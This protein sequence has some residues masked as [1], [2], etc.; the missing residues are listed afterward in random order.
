[1]KRMSKEKVIETIRSID[2]KGLFS[3]IAQTYKNFDNKEV[4]KKSRV[5]GEPTPARLQN[6]TILRCSTVSLG[7]DYTQAVNNR[8]LKEGKEADFQAKQSYTQKASENGL[9]LKHVEREQYYL[10]VYPNL[11]HSFHTVTKR[12]DANGVEISSEEWKKINAEYIK[13]KSPK[14]NQGLD[15][16]VL[17]NNYKIENVKYLKRGEIFIDKVTLEMEEKLAA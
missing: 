9:L 13:Q 10:R 6:I 17:V 8:L 2:E 16:E 11:C 4:L 14:K 12:Y 3:F 1:M 15:R 7:N 5:T